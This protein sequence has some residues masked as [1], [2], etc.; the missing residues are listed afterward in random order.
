MDTPK[1]NKYSANELQ[2]FETLI[3]DKLAK[4]HQELEFIQKSLSH[5][6]DNIVTTSS[7]LLED[8]A[9]AVENEI[10]S[11]LITRQRK[12]IV[13]LENALTRIKNGT[14]GICVV[15]GE[16]I[17]KERLKIVPHSRHSL[18]AKREKEAKDK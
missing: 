5:D 15:T 14:Y 3:Q 13:H 10:L 1:K 11:V 8:V 9:D 12:Y 6:A 4:A 18:Y 16:L 2:E 7:K 17:E